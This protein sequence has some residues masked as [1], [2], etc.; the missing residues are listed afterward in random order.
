MGRGE[1]QWMVS[2]NN[3][4]T[5]HFRD[6]RGRRGM[7]GDIKRCVS[8]GQGRDC[9]SSEGT[10]VSSGGAG[11][12]NVGSIGAKAA[13]GVAGEGSSSLSGKTRS[14]TWSNGEFGGVLGLLAEGVV[15]G[16]QFMFSEY[17]LRIG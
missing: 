10:V 5:R 1:T 3:A 15:R 7:D 2:S 6:E 17:K 4:G 9:S 16:T 11:G 8:T 14:Q 12:D 13:V